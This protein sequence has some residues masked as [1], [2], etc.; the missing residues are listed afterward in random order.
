MCCG[1]NAR[2]EQ[3][4]GISRSTNMSVNP[5]NGVSESKVIL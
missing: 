3:I 1:E 4:E 2:I 5:R